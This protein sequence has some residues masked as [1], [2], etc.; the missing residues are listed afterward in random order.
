MFC[1]KEIGLGFWG[2]LVWGFFGFWCFFGCFFFARRWK[3]RTHPGCETD[4]QSE[5]VINISLLP[6]LRFLQLIMNYS[7]DLS[8]PY[9]HKGVCPVI[10]IFCHKGRKFNLCT[11]HLANV[12]PS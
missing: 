12:E 7:V 11:V 10:S 2:V 6:V 4:C 8:Y 9:G 3:G 1:S 5:M